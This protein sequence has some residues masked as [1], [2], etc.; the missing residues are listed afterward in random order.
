MIS[1]VVDHTM[2]QT[3]HPTRSRIVLCMKANGAKRVPL[4]S[5][6]ISMGGVHKV[7][8]ELIEDIDDVNLSTTFKVIEGDI[9]KDYK[10]FKLTVKATPETADTSLVHWTIVYEK[11]KEE[12]PDSDA[13]SILDFVVHMSKDIDDHHV[14]IKNNN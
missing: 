6:T 2:S 8:K 11:L 13:I 3:W 7:A 5:G 10:E 9:T 1:S 12:F 14:K 4:L